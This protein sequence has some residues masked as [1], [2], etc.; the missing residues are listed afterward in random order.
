LII[1]IDH[2]Q[3]TKAIRREREREREKERDEHDVDGFVEMVF[4]LSSG[5]YLWV[6]CPSAH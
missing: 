1:I 2:P 3:G 4:L 5:R 6:V